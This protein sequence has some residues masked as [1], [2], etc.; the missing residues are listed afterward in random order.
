[1][2][3]KRLILICTLSGVL[4]ACSAGLQAI[5]EPWVQLDMEQVGQT[6]GLDNANSNGSLEPL[7]AQEPL[8]E[9]RS[10]PERST[11]PGTGRTSYDDPVFPDRS[12]NVTLPPQPLPA[13]VNTVFGEILEQPFTIGPEVVDR[14]ELITLRSVSDMPA[15]TFYGLVVEAL[16]DYGLGVQFENGLFSVIELNAL[17][18]QMPQFIVSRAH[19]DVP[20]GLRPVVQFINLKS[21][22]VADM[23]Q[24]LQQAFPDRSVI[25][26]RN[27][28]RTNALV[29]SGLANDVNAAVAIVDEMDTPRFAGTQVI[30]FTPRNWES[31]EL[32]N[33]MSEIMNLEGFMVGIGTAQPRATTLL[34]IGFTNQIMIFASERRLAE[35][36]L[37]LAIDLDEEAFSAETRTPHV[38]QV[39]HADAGALSEIIG[40]VV[41]GS[42]TRGNQTGGDQASESNVIS[43]ENVTVD[44]QGNR[45]IF[46]GT[47]REFDQLRGLLTQLDTPVPEVM[48]EVTIAEVTLTDNTQVGLE[49]LFNSEQVPRFSASL[50]SQSSFTGVLN[51]GEV[52]LNASASASNNQ[53]NV[54]ST[55]RIVTQSG[56][57]GAVQVG[58]DVPII[59]SQ[60]SSNSQSFG[61]SD[62]LQT[63]EYRSTGIITNVLP[64]VFSNNRIDLEISQEI[65]SAEPNE[66][67]DIA[68]P[69]ISTRSLTSKLSLQDG[70]TAVLG[71]LIENRFTRGNSGVPVV[72]DL[73]LVGAAFRNETLAA[74]RTMIVI[75]LTPYIL[76][77]R[78]D[79]QQIVDALVSTLNDGF[80]NQTQRNGTL[81]APNEP[82]QIRAYTPEES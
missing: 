31:T 60:S 30:T 80:T 7:I 39:Q 55:P 29:L 14:E 82:M 65:S 11:G 62:V 72:K 44:Q 53:I 61:S 73:P 52:R 27:D 26:I 66:N 9:R 67:P 32:V 50:N 49:V 21:I 47:R 75:L 54:L 64:T 22:D 76:D 70:Q 37:E 20:T 18:A 2:K 40:A 23:Q 10:V 13:F 59:T 57:T 58:T 51:T 4:A 5:N 25:N 17:R 43:F 41:G 33:A 28:R 38:Y 35:R 16:K 36:A 8:V 48:I 12:V 3:A 1:M 74:T 79:R 45:I 71:G 46:M 24:I 78:S 77:T 63:V 68:S 19:S 56:S 42:P 34:P 6:D 69:V 81:F 15:E